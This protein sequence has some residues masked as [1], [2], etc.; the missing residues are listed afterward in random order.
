M[1]T[2]KLVYGG[3]YDGKEDFAV[4]LQPF[5][6]NSAVPM[7]EVS[8]LKIPL[9]LQSCRLMRSHINNTFR[10]KIFM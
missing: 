4:V 3:R 9:S 5:F 2:E 7:L 6:K 1:E 10:H 8:V